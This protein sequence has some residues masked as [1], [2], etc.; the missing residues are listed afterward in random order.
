MFFWDAH[1][2]PHLHYHMHCKLKVGLERECRCVQAGRCSSITKLAERG[3]V[4]RRPRFPLLS[5][6][7]FRGES[8]RQSFLTFS[9]IYSLRKVMQRNLMSSLS[10][11]EVTAGIE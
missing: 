5:S 11:A 1:C 7:V 6:S 3:R 10:T 8:G 2:D 4:S 9:H